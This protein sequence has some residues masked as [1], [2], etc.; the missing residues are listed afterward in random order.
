MGVPKGGV[1]FFDSGIG[2]LTV[3]AECKKRM[4]NTTFYYYGDNAHAP[5]GNLS[6]EE[7]R[8]FV[9]RAVRRLQKYSPR[10]LVL[11]CNTATAVCVEELRKK[12]TVPVVGAEPALRLAAKE[13]GEVFV[14]STR[15]TYQS[16]RF[17]KLSKAISREY[18]KATVRAYACDGLA[19]EIEKGIRKG[20]GEYRK[21]LPKGAPASVVLGC[22]HYIFIREEIADFYGGCAVVDGN[23][24]IAKRLTQCL[25]EGNRE[26]DARENERAKKS[27]SLNHRRPLFAK[28]GGKRPEEGAEKANGSKKSCK[29][30]RKESFFRQKDG[31]DEGAIFFLGGHKNL[32]KRIYEQM[33]G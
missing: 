4:K 33:F 20:G 6:E 22:T 21:H 25:E 24:G 26:K 29:G 1:A 2:G 3:L 23:E 17:Q 16:Q 10:A 13:G 7:I 32:N 19:G 31:E 9:F 18:P 14:L 5:Y 30:R 11:A 27:I 12:L 28:G 15:A 8:R